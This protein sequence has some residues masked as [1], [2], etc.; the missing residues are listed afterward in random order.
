[1]YHYVEDKEF[2]SCMRNC[3]GKIM[4]DL[5]HELKVEY[6]IGAN[7]YLV[8]SGAKNLILQNEN[9]PIDLDYNLE[10]VRINDEL[11][12]NNCKDLK[13]CVRKAFNVV[14][15]KHNLK[16]CMDS[17]S[18][19]TTRQMCLKGNSTKFSIDVCITKKTGNSYMRLIHQ[20]ERVQNGWYNIYYSTISSGWYWN[21]A[22]NSFDLKKK[23]NYIKKRGKWDLVR[24]QYLAIKNR[25]LRLNDHNHPS[26]ICYIESI[27]NVYNQRYY[28]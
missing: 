9:N 15:K 8:G 21:E 2:L 23:V 12:L 28:W 14:L 6:D 3:C 26:F 16:D 19:L 17:T 24:S 7:F 18:S 4:Q 13:E 22:P 25:Y 20:K 11:G 5:C 27:N 1:M 10:I